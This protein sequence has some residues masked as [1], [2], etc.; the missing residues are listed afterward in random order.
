M[1]P[2]L[3]LSLSLLESCSR[4]MERNPQT[5]VHYNRHAKGRNVAPYRILNETNVR[6]WRGCI[7]VGCDNASCVLQASNPKI[8][9][10]TIL[11]T[12]CVIAA[13]GAVFFYP[14][15]YAKLSSY[16][17]FLVKIEHSEA[18]KA[19]KMNMQDSFP[20]STLSNSQSL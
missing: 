6:S 18:G 13:L 3:S 12:F 14:R 8:P 1:I 4:T 17:R 9:Y 11:A 5:I 16:Y 10:A 7:P 20:P 19:S 2:P 15:S